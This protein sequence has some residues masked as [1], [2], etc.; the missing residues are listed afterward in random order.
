[1]AY[2]F[3]SSGGN[4]T[5]YSEAQSIGVSGYR[6]SSYP[7]AKYVHFYT[8]ANDGS[9][10]YKATGTFDN[11]GYVNTSLS[12]TFY[13]GKS[14]TVNLYA[15]HSTSP[16]PPSSNPSLSNIQDTLNITLWPTSESVTVN[17]SQISST[18][19]EITLTASE[20]RSQYSRLYTI[21]KDSEEIG[22]INI[23]QGQTFG[24]TLVRATNL[25]PGVTY[26]YVALYSNGYSSGIGRTSFAT[27]ETYASV[28]YG[29][30]SYSSSINSVR[31][32]LT[33]I[34]SRSYERIVRYYWENTKTGGGG[35]K[36]ESLPANQT[37]AY[38]DMLNLTAD[39]QYKFRICVINLEGVITYDTGYF[40]V[41]TLSYDYELSMTLSSTY[42]S[43]TVTVTLN[44]TLSYD[45][46]LTVQ[47]NGSRDLDISISAGSITRSQTWTSNINAAT[48]YSI[49]LIDKTRNKTFTSTKRTKNNFHW[50]TTIVSGGTFNLKASDWNKYT[51]Q[52]SSKASYYGITYNPATVSKG[53]ELTAE[54]FNNIVAT[55]N[56]LVD[57][58]KGDCIT[59]M[60]SVSK[61][62]P[63]TASC[64]KKLATCLNE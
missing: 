7:T 16:S 6:S 51:G 23:P 60:S 17:V 36:D 62:E 63:V 32:S 48:A 56:K 59:R 47:L 28:D 42:N 40:Y 21:K 34:T 44:K 8:R 4:V 35:E 1:M 46:D 18:S 43:V 33:S 61:G 52:L 54:K 39:T 38:R 5:S 55:I 24:N 22:T 12:F 58:N 3:S 29:S 20:A 30:Y 15:W 26:T 64:I 49:K 9:L 57:G 14:Y 19:V 37:S 50:S 10:K 11:S 25:T 13:F 2:S 45:I 31:L 53:D 41:T 27:K